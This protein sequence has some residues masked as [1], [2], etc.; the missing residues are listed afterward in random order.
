ML[1]SFSGVPLSHKLLLSKKANKK[2]VNLFHVSHCHTNWYELSHAATTTSIFLR[3]HT[4][5]QIAMQW[6]GQQKLQWSVWGVTLSNNSVSSSTGI[7][8]FTNL[9]SF[10]TLAQKSLCIKMA[11]KNCVNIF[12][13][14]TVTQIAIQ[15]KLHQSFWSVTLSHKL[16][17]SRTGS[18]NYCNLSQVSHCHTNCNAVRQPA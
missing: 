4:V 18:K 8:K 3:C 6:D 2:C 12:R 13:C 7:K 15:W 14:H 11:S 16:L 9:N 5:T 10:V 17:K 1:E